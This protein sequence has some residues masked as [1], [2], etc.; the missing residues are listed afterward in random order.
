MEPLRDEIAEIVGSFM[1]QQPHSFMVTVASQ[2]IVELV[3]KR[4]NEGIGYELTSKSSI[5]EG[6]P[7]NKLLSR[8]VECLE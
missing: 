7:S 1:G 2:K 3:R 6:T 8:I 5:V 4:L